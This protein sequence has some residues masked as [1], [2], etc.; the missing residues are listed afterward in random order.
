MLP[1]RYSLQFHLQRLNVDY[2]VPSHSFAAFFLAR[3]FWAQYDN[4]IQDP[5]LAL[6]RFEHILRS[7]EIMSIIPYDTIRARAS[8]WMEF[9]KLIQ[10]MNAAVFLEI[11]HPF[12][13][14][15]WK[16][17]ETIPNE[18]L[19]PKQFKVVL[20]FLLLV[21]APRFNPLNE[22]F[23]DNQ[24]FDAFQ[25]K[26]SY[27]NS[28]DEFLDVWNDFFYCELAIP[29]QPSKISQITEVYWYYRR[30][31]ITKEQIVEDYYLK[32]FENN[33]INESKSNKKSR[34]TEGGLPKR[35]GEMYEKINDVCNSFRPTDVIQG[36]YYGDDRD[37]S[38]FEYT[39][40]VPRIRQYHA[41]RKNI[42]VVNPS[43]IVLKALEKLPGITVAVKEPLIMKMY[44]KQFTETT[45]FCCSQ[46]AQITDKF[47]GVFIFA[48]DFGYQSYADAL[49]L[50]SKDGFFLLFGP[51]TLLSG[52]KSAFVA[53]L[54]RFQI[55]PDTVLSVDREATS[56][57]G[58]KKVVVTCRV[59][60]DHRCNEVQL[61]SSFVRREHFYVEKRYS[62]PLSWFTDEHLTVNMVLKRYDG[63]ESLQEPSG[64]Y[65][66]PSVYW[67]SPEIGLHYVVLHRKN[68]ISAKVCYRS[69]LDQND[70]KDR[71]RKY[72]ENLTGFTEQG[73]RCDSEEQLPARLEALALSEKFSEIIRNDFRE[74]WPDSKPLSMKTIW[75]LCRENLQKYVVGYRDE[76]MVE[77]FT[78]CSK[79]LQDIL[80]SQLELK[81]LSQMLL[82]E[83]KNVSKILLQYHLIL[84]T[85]QSLGYVDHYALSDADQETIRGRNTRL[86]DL[87]R[88]MTKRHLT[89]AEEARIMAYLTEPQGRSKTSRC[90]TES[91]LLIGLIRLYTG[92]PLREV[93]A[94]QWKHFYQDPKTGGYS[95]ILCQRI[96]DDGTCAGYGNF[97]DRWKL[98]KVPLHPEITSSLLARLQWL[99]NS[100]H[101]SM[102]EILTQPII[103][104]LEPNRN[105]R[106]CAWRY[107][108]I[109]TG[110]KV[111]RSI[112]DQAKIPENKILLPGSGDY[113]EHDLNAY[114]GDMFYAN[115]LHRAIHTCGFSMGQRCYVTGVDPADTFS[116]NYVDYADS[117][118]QYQMIR[119]LNRWAVAAVSNDTA[120][121][122]VLYQL[123]P[124]EGKWEADGRP[125]LCTSVDG[126]LRKKSGSGMLR[127]TI[128][129]E[130]GAELTVKQF[131]TGGQ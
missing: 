99:Q 42:L 14:H 118:V 63:I 90:V 102:E 81:N 65:N 34:K 30:I 72:G 84:R 131:R 82:D 97:S 21:E 91:L 45:F 109:A 85:A 66:E 119:K 46:L 79:A 57:F 22:D 95:M 36:L 1:T 29:K 104:S 10:R 121:G 52:A 11:L 105:R 127:V 106:K 74:K 51:E 113:F 116:G 73:M 40:L 86:Q 53:D 78:S 103:L 60:T 3:L 4:G 59:G 89:D 32:K 9:A 17:M 129:S 64:H 122:A 58:R 61:L 125:N 6:D 48:R 120:E 24:A 44:A 94:L 93:L 88:S 107:C 15:S 130:H 23:N 80:T 19:D 18:K 69:L 75:Y 112:L 62:T 114:S 76:M 108:D 38:A 50:C 87:R 27:F 39:V 77:F 67:F 35:Q 7:T 54:A 20:I 5:V 71:R 110:R 2:S 68:C 31:G 12:Y 124:G 117:I 101:F 49:R 98:R 41:E 56:S 37:D 123:I 13:V 33:I 70:A 111:T 43:P 128:D 126:D 92:M 8:D 25:H 28:L 16:K 115:F 100:L 55:W 96:R 83:G 47:D 26:S